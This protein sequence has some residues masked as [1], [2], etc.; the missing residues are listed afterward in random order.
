MKDM[1]RQLLSYPSFDTRRGC[2]WKIW[3]SALASGG[4]GE[5]ARFWL[6]FNSF[7]GERASQLQRLAPD[8]RLQ[9]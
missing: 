3:A 1:W 5:A 2:S 8:F 4:F 6:S 9:Y 7:V